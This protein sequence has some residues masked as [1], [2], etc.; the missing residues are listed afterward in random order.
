VLVVFEP[1]AQIGD[2]LVERIRRILVAQADE[3]L[4][5]QVRPDRLAVASKVPGDRR[6]RPASLA[7]SGCLHVLSPCE[8][9]RAGPPSVGRGLDAT[10][11][12]RVPFSRGGLVFSWWSRGGWSVHR[13]P[14]VG[15]FSEQVWGALVSVITADIS[16]FAKASTR[17]RSTSGLAVASAHGQPPQGHTLDDGQIAA[18]LNERP[19][20]TLSWAAPA[21]RFKQLVAATG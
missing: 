10:S 20:K 2:E 14:R 6:D 11:L 1:D 19:R 18:V 12:R 13:D 5:V 16:A 17:S 8:H 9:M 4:A 21:E 15:N 3:A 7:Q